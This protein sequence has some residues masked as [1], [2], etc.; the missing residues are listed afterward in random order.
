MFNR[1]VIDNGLFLDDK[2]LIGVREYSVVQHED[3]NDND[4]DNDIACLT[5]KMDV[6]ILR[7][8]RHRHIDN[9]EEV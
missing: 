2:R 9:G 6:T 8:S 7:H 1:L 3:D 5:L 4:N